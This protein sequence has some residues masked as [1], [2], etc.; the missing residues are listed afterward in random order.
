MYQI[1]SIK[2]GFNDSWQTATNYNMVAVVSNCFSFQVNTRAYMHDAVVRLPTQY[3][4]GLLGF[5]MTPLHCINTV[6]KTGRLE[7]DNN[8]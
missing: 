5:H 8:V 4:K 1:K 3:A 6:T 7:V 2:Y